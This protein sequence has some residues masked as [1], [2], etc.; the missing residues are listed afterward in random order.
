VINANYTA[1]TQS[2]FGMPASGRVATA[3]TRALPIFMGEVSVL[4]MAVKGADVQG[5]AVR[6]HR[7]ATANGTLPGTSV[8]SPPT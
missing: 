4:G 7:V 6:K 2:C 5:T 3:W 1:Q 8:W